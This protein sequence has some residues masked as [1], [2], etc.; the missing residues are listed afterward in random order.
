MKFHGVNLAGPSQQ[1]ELAD[2]GGR[3]DGN[4]ARDFYRQVGRGRGV[5]WLKAFLI[6]G[7]KTNAP[8]YIGNMSRNFLYEFML[9]SKV[10][11]HWIDVPTA[12]LNTG[13]KVFKTHGK[14]DETLISICY[15]V[16][17]PSSI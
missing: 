9:I 15:Y 2:K 8:M 11:V 3:Y 5:A 6:D 10:P 17:I 16:F 14:K 4:L 1:L 12:D 13:E 7:I